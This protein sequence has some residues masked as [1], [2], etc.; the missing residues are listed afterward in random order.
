[1]A[2][3]PRRDSPFASDRRRV[4]DVNETGRDT[5]RQRPHGEPGAA[6]RIIASWI[7]NA[8]RQPAL[9]SRCRNSG[10]GTLIKTGNRAN[11]NFLVSV[12]IH[13]VF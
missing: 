10:E 5:S 7:C 9:D 11:G 12:V 8:E 6:D 2:N 4:A 13:K 1:M 3:L